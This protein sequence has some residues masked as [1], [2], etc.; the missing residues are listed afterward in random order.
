[1]PHE[2]KLRRAAELNRWLIPAFRGQIKKSE[3][4]QITP[5]CVYIHIQFKCESSSRRAGV[6]L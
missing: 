6:H 1:M 4:I 2:T 5:E 3:S